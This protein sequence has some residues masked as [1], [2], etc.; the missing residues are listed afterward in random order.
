MT[1]HEDINAAIYMS[2]HAALIMAS[3]LPQIDIVCDLHQVLK[4][5]L[6]IIHGVLDGNNF[7]RREIIDFCNKCEDIIRNFED[8]EVI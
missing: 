1:N 3:Q 6:A 8:E 4:I 2:S 7:K 5:Q